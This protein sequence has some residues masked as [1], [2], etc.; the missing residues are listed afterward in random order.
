[1]Y[2]TRWFSPC[3][4]GSARG[5]GGEPHCKKKSASVPR[6]EPSAG[7]NNRSGRARSEAAS[8]A[9]PN[10]HLS[11]HDVRRRIKQNRNTREYGRN[12]NDL[13]N[14]IKDRRRIRDKTPSPPSRFLA[15]DVKPTGR[16]GFHALERPL[17]EVRWPAMFKAGH[18][19]RYDGPNN[20]KEFI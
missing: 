4:S 20:P 1:V 6:V 9:S 5:R 11:E 3:T 15:R 10:R 16:S 2:D 19:D 7:R 13:R 14:V 12:W 17:R 18:I 8:S